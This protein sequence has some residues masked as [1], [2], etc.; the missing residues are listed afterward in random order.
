MPD[1]TPQA[2]FRCPTHGAVVTT[3]ITATVVCGGKGKVKCGLKCSL[4]PEDEEARKRLLTKRRVAA[5][6]SEAA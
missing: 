1:E 2:T 4:G 3:Y 5:H 6:R